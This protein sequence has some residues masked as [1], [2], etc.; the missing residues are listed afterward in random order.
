VKNPTRLCGFSKAVRDICGGI[1]L[2]LAF[3]TIVGWL[4]WLADWIRVETT[5]LPLELRKVFYLTA[6]ISEDAIRQRL[7][8][9]AEN[10]CVFATLTFVFL[11]P[12]I[13]AAVVHDRIKGLADFES[14]ART[15]CPPNA[16]VTVC[17]SRASI[18]LPG[19]YH[20]RL[21]KPPLVPMGLVEVAR[22]LALRGLDIFP[23]SEYFYVHIEDSKGEADA[24][25][26]REPG[27][28]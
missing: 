22:K 20:D 25:F 14:A 13:I 9:M 7:P 3:I 17:S 16:Q 11:V 23:K 12:G 6:G 2:L 10:V 1:G 24:T 26:Y 27:S 19:E 21:S 15:F 5:W 18:H 8:Q 4:F 28:P